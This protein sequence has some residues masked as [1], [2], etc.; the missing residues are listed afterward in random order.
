MERYK[1]AIKD[2]AYFVKETF[3]TYEDSYTTSRI[4][5]ERRIKGLKPALPPPV[6]KTPQRPPQNQNSNNLRTIVVQQSTPAYVSVL[7]HK[8]PTFSRKQA[9]WESYKSRLNAKFGNID[10]ISPVD[11]LQHL[12][13]C[14]QGEA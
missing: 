12:M 10:T 3:L 13:S 14:V 9:D 8:L 5:L 11:K 2:D 7:K 4:E 6:L 1:E